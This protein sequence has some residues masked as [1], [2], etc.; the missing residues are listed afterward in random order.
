MTLK[1]NQI[2]LEDWQVEYI[3]RSAAALDFS[4]SETT[5]ILISEAILSILFSLEP[6]KKIGITS[7]ELTKL[8][9]AMLDKRTSVEERHRLISKVYFEARKACEH[10][11]GHIRVDVSA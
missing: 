9:K 3:K 11:I 5:R 10:T 7:S 4:F 8:K 6:K 2:L 1:R